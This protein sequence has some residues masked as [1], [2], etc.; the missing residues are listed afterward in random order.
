[1]LVSYTLDVIWAWHFLSVVV[2]LETY[3]S[4]IILRKV[5]NTLKWRDVLWDAGQYS[6]KLTRSSDARKVW[7]SVTDWLRR[8]DWGILDEIQEWEKATRKKKQ[9]LSKTWVQCGIYLMVI[10]QCWLLSYS[11]RTLVMWGIIYEENC[12]QSIWLLFVQ[13]LKLSHESKF[14]LK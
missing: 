7:E 12:M 1:M 10:H 6:S 5:S 11:E 13:S 14:F 3:N 9:N 8:Q 4:S 2:H